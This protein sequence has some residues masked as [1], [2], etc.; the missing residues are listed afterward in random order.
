[1]LASSIVTK[2]G[3]GTLS[4]SDFLCAVTLFAPAV[5]IENSSACCD[6]RGREQADDGRSILV[7]LFEMFEILL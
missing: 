5:L 2:R 3:S 4:A 6:L 7:S 1:M